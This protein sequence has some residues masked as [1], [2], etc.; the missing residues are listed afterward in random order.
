MISPARL[1][2]RF[3]AEQGQE[4]PLTQRI[5]TIGREPI[6]DIV[7]DDAEISRRHARILYEDGRFIIE[8]L[9][10]TNGTFVNGERLT[11]PTPLFSGAT[12]DFAETFR[13]TFLLGDAPVG[14]PPT[15]RTLEGQATLLDLPPPGPTEV[16]P[17][18]P[19]PVTL[20][21]GGVATEEPGLETVPA[22][23]R[24]RWVLGCGCLLLVLAFVC[25]GGA[26]F[27]DSYQGGE[28]LYCGPLRPLFESL[29]ATLGQALRCGA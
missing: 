22:G 5:T 2:P 14:R 15:G 17:Y 26:F 27:L 28:L 8:D 24:R 1:V 20:G 11:R 23:R 19:A 7:L 12:L 9:N 13:F 4:Y 21:A 16:Y 6:N 25:A 18:E 29:A 3:G 10:S